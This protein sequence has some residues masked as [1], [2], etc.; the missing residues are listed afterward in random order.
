MPSSPSDR[1]KDGGRRMP[2]KMSDPNATRLIMSSPS[3]KETVIELPS[4]WPASPSIRPRLTADTPIPAAVPKPA[5]PVRRDPVGVVRNFWGL[6]TRATASATTSAVGWARQGDTEI[7][8][9]RARE[10]RAFMTRDP[11][12][13]D[14]FFEDLPKK[15]RPVGSFLGR[16]Q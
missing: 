14:D 6:M 16:L 4:G 10:L 5:K 11:K 15:A 3:G 7:S 13:L 8:L 12:R 1:N 9:S 2:D